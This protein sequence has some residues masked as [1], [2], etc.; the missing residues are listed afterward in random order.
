MK[1][2]LH[3]AGVLAISLICV[4]SSCR[5]RGGNGADEL[6]DEQKAAIESVVT[7][8]EAAARAL[9]SIA[10]SFEAIDA[11]GDLQV[12][13][14]PVVTAEL[15]GGILTVNV[16]FPAGCTNDYYGEDI[17]VS[18]GVT[19]VFDINALSLD[20]TFDDFASNGQTVSGSL[21]MTLTREDLRR[22]LTGTIDITTTGVGSVE[23]NLEI[24]Y[25]SARARITIHDANLALTDADGVSVSIAIDGIVIEPIDNGNFIPE[26]GTVTFVLPATDSTDEATIEVEFD[27]ESPV[28]GTVSVT[29]DGHGPVPYS[30]LALAD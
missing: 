22:T 15:A 17:A 23:G 30:L 5:T 2:S 9:T 25:D 19:I 20:V 11:E 4:S 16:N 27:Q 29:V 10:Q 21:S 7:Q 3:F 26:A 12:G 28:D 8:V 1:A 14:C 18:G 13:E 6:T 24:E